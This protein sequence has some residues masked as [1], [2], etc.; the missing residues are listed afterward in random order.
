MSTRDNKC[1]AV[2]SKYEPAPIADVAV[3]VTVW[4]SGTCVHRQNNS[5][6]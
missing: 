5:I 6:Q 4:T 2:T 1:T 3:V